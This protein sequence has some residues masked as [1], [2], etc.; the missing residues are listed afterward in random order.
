[1]LI[2]Y[3][4]RTPGSLFKCNMISSIIIGGQESDNFILHCNTKQYGVFLIIP[5][6]ALKKTCICVLRNVL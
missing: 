4:N 5:P 3:P 2:G 1:M 6:N